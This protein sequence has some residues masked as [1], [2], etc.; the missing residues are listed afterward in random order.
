MCVS[1]SFFGME[2]MEGMENTTATG[3]LA[4]T[5]YKKGLV[6]ME[7]PKHEEFESISQANEKTAMEV[8]AAFPE[9]AKIREQFAEVFGEGLRVVAVD[10][11]GMEI[12][13]N[14]YRADDSYHGCLNASEFILL[15]EISR[16]LD[17]DI[18]QREQRH[19]KK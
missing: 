3:V 18:K 17:A 13:T 6:G 12:R 11:A 2:G 14:N 19:G 7:N 15:G 16:K 9:A 4:S 8:R 1:V 10:E 5:P